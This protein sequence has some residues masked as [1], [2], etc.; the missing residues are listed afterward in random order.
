MALELD[1]FAVLRAIAAHPDVFADVRA[2]LDKAARACVSKQLKARTTDV[3]ALR[4]VRAAIGQRAFSLI[5]DGLKE[6]E[7]KTLVGKLDRFRPRLKSA[8]AEWRRRHLRSLADSSVDAA[9]KS[10]PPRIATVSKTKRDAEPDILSSKA[11][12]AVRRR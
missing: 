11:M 12:A 4:A 10:A 2:E 7:V 1:V 8:D 6:A 9:V 3:A 5:V